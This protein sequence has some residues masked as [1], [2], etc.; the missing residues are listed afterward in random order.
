VR[1]KGGSL[2]KAK[3]CARHDKRL[4]W[5]AQGPQGAPGAPGAAGAPGPRGLQGQPGPSRG[6]FT[7]CST[8]TTHSQADGAGNGQQQTRDCTTTVTVPTAGKLLA[9]GSGEVVTQY[10]ACSGGEVL[11]L[12]ELEIDGSPLQGQSQ[13]NVGGP[14]ASR[15]FALSAGAN[16]A[17]GAHTVTFEMTGASSGVC[18]AG[19]DLALQTTESVQVV[20][21][22]GAS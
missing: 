7:V 6:N 1:H 14:N 10:N 2:Y 21:V 12:A 20:F 13:F 9:V 22:E 3:R 4:S 15:S 18:S 11:Q 16:V 19:T 17:A 8:D 5:N